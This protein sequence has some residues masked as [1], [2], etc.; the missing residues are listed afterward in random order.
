M[1]KEVDEGSFPL[2]GTTVQMGDASTTLEMSFSTKAERFEFGEED[3]VET[4]PVG[5]VNTVMTYV[6]ISVVVGVGIDT[7]MRARQY[8]A[9]DTDT[10]QSVFG[11]VHFKDED[12]SIGWHPHR[13]GLGDGVE[14]DGCGGGSGFSRTV[15]DVLF[16]GV[17]VEAR[18]GDPH[19]MAVVRVWLR[20]LL[21]LLCFPCFPCFPCFSCFPCFH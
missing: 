15:V 10:F 12:E 16:P 4:E 20:V 3:G 6:S 2:G 17:I 21:L 8:I 7:M 14:A 9:N 11:I 18:G 19:E 13:H 1:A 5:A